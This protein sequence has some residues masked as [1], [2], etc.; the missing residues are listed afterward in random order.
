[1]KRRTLLQLL[2]SLAAA[3]PRPGRLLA[4]ASPLGPSDEA[5]IRALADVV[6]PDELGPGGRDT[7]VQSFAAWVRDYRANAETDHGYGF[8]RLR[9]T[10]P[11]PAANYT[12]Q[13]N[14]LDDEA[15]K[16]GRSFVDLPRAERIEIVEAA[17]AAAKIDRLPARPDG[18]HI[19]TDL[20]ALYFS[21]IEANDLCY[22]AK[23]GRDT[24]R[25][26]SGSGDRP[27]PL[28]AGGR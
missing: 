16:R 13:L 7:A 20:M 17:L 6:L 21:S 14:A 4:Q 28:V 15:R 22:R 18:G 1:M 23:I 19:A 27:A 25:A 10:G 8:T 24:C 5:R 9:R 11:S 26:L 12:A 2:G 3:C